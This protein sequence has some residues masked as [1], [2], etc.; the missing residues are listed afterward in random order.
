MKIAEITATFPPY[1]GGVGHVAYHNARLLAERGHEV[2]VITQATRQDT[3]QVVEAAAFAVQRLPP[4]ISFGNAPILPQLP[5]A[6]KG[7]D[8]IHFHYP[9]IFGAEMVM[10]SA[11]RHQIPVAMTYHNRLVE[12]DGIKKWLFM[13]YNAV[14]ERRL[15][16]HATVR[17]AVSLDHFTSLFP[18]LDAIEVPNGVDTTLFV[19]FNQVIARQRL[20]LPLSR[21]IALFVGGLDAAH[22]FKN[23][24]ALLRV[25]AQIPDLEVVIVG[26]GALRPSLMSLSHRLGMTHRTVFDNQCSTF[27]LPL[28]Y[29]AADVTVL[30]SNRTESFGMVL[31]ESMACA[32]PVL[33]TDLPGVR[34]VV[35]PEQTGLLVPVNDE[36]ALLGSLR[37]LLNH[38]AERHEMGRRGR[39]HVEH[40]Y[41]WPIVAKAL[42]KACEKAVGAHPVVPFQLTPRAHK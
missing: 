18:D 25:A 5:A 35:Q 33:A 24:P 1:R 14:R 28:Y 16:E 40:H 23:V 6:V 11:A 10:L 19:P 41:A 42:E 32:T 37:W 13:F 15:L 7:Y 17:I 22:R 21:P 8:L 3:E 31:A 30:P 38:D 12:D 20:Q 36:N 26:S 2:T 27:R 4:L 29:Q 34:S 39:A 9:F